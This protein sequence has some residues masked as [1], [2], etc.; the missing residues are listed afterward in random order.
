MD[1]MLRPLVLADME[2]AMDL[3]AS[4]GWNQTLEDWTFLITD[5]H[6]ICVAAAD[7]DQLVGTTIVLDYHGRLGWVGMVLV[8]KAWRGKGISRLLLEYVVEKYRG[9]L[10][11]DATALGEPVYRKFGFVK[12]YNIVRLVNNCVDSAVQHADE[13]IVNVH[14]L[15]LADIIKSDAAAFGIERDQLVHYLHNRYPAKAWLLE[16][17]AVSGFI[18]GRDGHRYHHLGPLVADSTKTASVLILQALSSLSGQAV[19]IDVLCEKK[20]LIAWLEQRGFVEQRQFVRM[21]KGRNVFPEKA[22]HLFA[23]A[24]PELG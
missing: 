11:L 6:N 19:V 23:I 15:H 13:S 20:E 5:P 2:A 8:N 18:F 22:D 16:K 4:E 3:S 12:E 17:E 7:A 21:Y 10:K 1:I 9:I 24:G 14:S